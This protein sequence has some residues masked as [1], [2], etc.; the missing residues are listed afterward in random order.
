MRLIRSQRCVSFAPKFQP[1]IGACGL[2]RLCLE[3]TSQIFKE[4]RF[5][6]RFLLFG[7]WE[8]SRKLEWIVS[9]IS[10]SMNSGR[11]K[12]K[13]RRKLLFLL[14]LFCFL[15]KP[16]ILLK[17]IHFQLYIQNKKWTLFV[18]PGLPNILTLIIFYTIRFYEYTSFSFCHFAVCSGMDNRKT[19]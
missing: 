7:K 8:A 1:F 17:F 14:E 19:G 18:I 2:Q 12:N 4:E 11:G 13:M 16:G 3:V 5:C 10:L 9:Y 6:S 15:F